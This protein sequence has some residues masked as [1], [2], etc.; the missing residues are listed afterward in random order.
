MKGV[1]FIDRITMHAEAGTGGNG[2][3]SFRREKFVPRGGPDGGDGGRG[4]HV[5]IRGSKDVSSL[6]P[7]YYRPIQKAQRGEHGKGKQCYG[8]SGK[9]CIVK[10]P[11]GTE[12]RIADTGDWLGEV[13]DD[14]EEVV[15][16][17][18]GKGGL[19]NCHFVTSSHQ[20]PTECTEGEEGETKDL[21]LELKT[22]ADVGLVGYPNAGKSTL[23][24]AISHAHPKVASYPFTT[25]FPVIG[26]VQFDD[27]KTIRVADIPGLI[28]GAHEG[29]GLGHDFLRHIERTQFLLF[30][31]DMSGENGRHPVDDFKNLQ[32]ELKLYKHELVERPYYIVGNKMDAPEFDKLYKEFVEQ[33]GEE[34]LPISAELK[35]NT[36]KLLAFL[37]KRFHPQATDFSE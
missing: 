24:T 17:R 10:V 5:I 20:A 29:V 18:G 28:D 12:I 11:C 36:D 13:T 3:S 7:I 32:K 37:H 8:R 2:C 27:F 21:L 33:T 15:V 16:A 1:K 19:G 35:E 26:T 34:V 9:D 14:E 22:V 30:V 31:L 6:L 4:G 23:L 25:L